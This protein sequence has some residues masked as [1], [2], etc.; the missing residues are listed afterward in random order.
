MR[1]IL[2]DALRLVGIG[3]LIGPIA[4]YFAT[5]FVEKM[6]YGVSGFDPAT[7]LA[8]GLLLTVVALIAGLLPALR[9]ASIDPMQALRGE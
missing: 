9:A 5:A 4:L 7:L 6:L 2:S 1:L 8:T 3:M